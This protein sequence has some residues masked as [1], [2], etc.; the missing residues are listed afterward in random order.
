MKRLKRI[1]KRML[2]TIIS[3]LLILFV[4]GA[5]F[6]N[7]SP[8][9]GGTIGETQKERFLKS[10]NFKNGVFENLGGVKMNMGFSDYIK[11]MR[12]FFT[13]QPNT[14]PT[15]NLPTVKVD[16]LELV[17]YSG[18]ARL[19]W[20]GHSAFLFQKNGKNILID[21]MFGPVPAPHPVLGGKR[22]Q[23]F[24]NEQCELWRL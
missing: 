20:F 6:V 24:M 4:L 11:G 13:V 9:F 22:R 8:E 2:I 19:I 5:L 16:S 23:V 10:P 17:N 7:L 15:G 14:R 3:V 12:S 18:A 1:L 21:P